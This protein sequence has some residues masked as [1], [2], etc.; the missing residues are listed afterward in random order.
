ML[1]LAPKSPAFIGK[2]PAFPFINERL[3]IFR[4]EPAS[5]RGAA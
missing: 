2:A 3:A 5:P 4:L 1:D